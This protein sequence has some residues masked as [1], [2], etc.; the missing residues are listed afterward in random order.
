MAAPIEQQVLGVE[1]LLSMRSQSRDGG[2]YKLIVT[3][4]EGVDLDMA[5]V[6]V[7]NRV[8]LALP[9]LP[10]PLRQGGVTV[11][12]RSPGVFMI[13]SLLSPDGRYDELYLANY[14]TSQLRDELNRL[15]GVAAVAL[16]PQADQGVHVSLDHDETAARALTASDV[17]EAIK[18]QRSQVIRQE[19]ES[20]ADRPTL[21]S[22]G[23]N[24]DDGEFGR[25]VLKTDAQGNA[26]RLGDVATIQWGGQAGR[27][28]AICD[29]RPAVLLLIYSLPEVEPRALITTLE[30]K[31]SELVARLPGGVAAEIAFAPPLD[32]P[33]G[34][35]LPG[36]LLLDVAFSGGV[37]TDGVL[38][39]LR[40]VEKLL[41]QV[42]GVQ[43]VLAMSENPFNPF[44][45]QACI[46]VRLAPP[47]SDPVSRERL[48]Q[49]I[50]SR[51]EPIHEVAVGVR[52][53]SGPS[54]FPLFRDPV[55]LA[56]CGPELRGVRDLGT[57][58]AE[59]L[60]QDKRLLDVRGNWESHP[61]PRFAANI[62]SNA[63]KK[64]GV[65]IADV[66]GTLYVFFNTPKACPDVQDDSR[67]GRTS[68]V[69]VAANAHD[70]N[71]IEEIKRLMVR[72]AAGRMIPLSSLVTLEK[73]QTPETVDRLDGQPMVE[74]IAN[75]AGGTSLAEIRTLCLTLFDEIRK[76]LGLSAEFTLVWQ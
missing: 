50:R 64:Q 27:G 48:A 19:G 22:L 33:P 60:R 51:I 37:S 23:R 9:V 14:A 68:P 36:Y 67:S 62:D 53:L 66:L 58:L 3:F 2:S 28:Y 41:R 65:A 74:I 15:P 16:L 75:S 30:K 12:K 69:I 61:R 13:V 5:Q 17:P 38:Q 49:T 42:N 57:K 24:I 52:D 39:I 43:A 76:D 8:A 72:G 1:K 4:Q 6:L 7:Q 44:R 34:S 10:D 70:S 40:R 20:P 32:V 63:V 47:A 35:P 25:T 21:N 71:P 55:D 31:L 18:R 45:N 26:V 29:G 46:L 54:G 59:R 11:R 73:V 56:I